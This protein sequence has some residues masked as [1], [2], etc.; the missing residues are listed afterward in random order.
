M[1]NFIIVGIGLVCGVRDTMCACG[2]QYAYWV[3]VSVP[4]DNWRF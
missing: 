1:L 3:C 4:V 2:W